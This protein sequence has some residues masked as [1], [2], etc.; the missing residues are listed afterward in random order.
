[1]E[2]VLTVTCHQDEE[3]RLV[4]DDGTPSMFPT[5]SKWSKQKNSNPPAYIEE[6]EA[7]MD[8]LDLPEDGTIGIKDAPTGS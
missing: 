5:P 4:R 3:S 2:A 7:D 1:M 8:D 6:N